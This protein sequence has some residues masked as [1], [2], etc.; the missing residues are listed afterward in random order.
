MKKNFDEDDHMFIMKMGHELDESGI[1]QKRQNKVVMYNKE[2]IS[3]R[4]EK[5]KQADRET[6]ENNARL[7]KVTLIFDKDCN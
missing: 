2:K 4:T 1:E 5:Q 6:A 3:K 7:A